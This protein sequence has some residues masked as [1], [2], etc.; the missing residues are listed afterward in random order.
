M[1]LR[2]AVSGIES[3][4]QMF[5]GVESHFRDPDDEAVSADNSSSFEAFRLSLRVSISSYIGSI[6]DKKSDGH[7]LYPKAFEFQ[8]VINVGT[9]QDRE[10]HA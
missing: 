8:S 5:C 1:N 10:S 7:Y 9:R 2:S 4:N 3:D 6:L